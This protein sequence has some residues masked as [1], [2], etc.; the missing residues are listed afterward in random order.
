[1]TRLRGTFVFAAMAIGSVMACTSESSDPGGAKAVDCNVTIERFKELEIVD[2]AV[3]SDPRSSNEKNGPWS[4]RHLV[5]NMAPAGKDPSEFVSAWF[6]DWMTR[7]TFNGYTLDR[8]PRDEM[9]P[10]ILCP[11]YKRTP[12][13]QCDDTCKSCTAHKLD[14]AKA[15]FRLMGIANRQDL[16]K[17]PDARSPSGEGRLLFSLTDGPGDDPASAPAPMS[18]IFE[19]GLPTSQTT[20]QWADEWH[21]LGTHAAFDEAYKAELEALTRKFTSRGAS[22]EKRNGSAIGQ[23]R[24]NESATSWIWQLREFTLD[25]NGALAVSGTSNTPAE[26]LSGTPELARLIESKKAEILADTFVVPPYMV[27]GTVDQLL[28]A[29]DLPGIDKKLAI[30]FARTTCNGC[31]GT[32]DTAV[33]DTTFQVS[34]FKKGTDRL[35]RFIYNPEAPGSDD[36]GRRELVARELLCPH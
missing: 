12:S 9:V 17:R 7:K 11:W 27:S 22:P 1:M 13:N 6:N 3:V 5:E 23:V 25:V 33:L 15:P 8:E 29:W 31:H 4:F 30:A 34:P 20:Q 26:A 35:S 36:L 16:R 32:G 18:M 14:L 19:F 10:R 2:D 21:H 28:F 24:V